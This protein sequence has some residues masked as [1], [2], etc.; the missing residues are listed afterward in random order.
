[1][2]MKSVD[3]RQLGQVSGGWAG[4]GGTQLPP[5]WW[6]PCPFP[7]PYPNPFPDPLP[8]PFPGPTWPP[9]PQQN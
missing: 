4:A 8:G 1:M 2:T 5:D 7:A 6:I 3:G 9:L